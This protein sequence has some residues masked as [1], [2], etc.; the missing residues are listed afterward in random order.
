MSKFDK[1]IQFIQGLHPGREFIPLHEPRFDGNEKK[2]V[3]DAL[4]STFVS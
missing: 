3:M 2:Y 1:T 4:D